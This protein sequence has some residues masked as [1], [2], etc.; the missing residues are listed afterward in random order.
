MIGGNWKWLIVSDMNK[1]LV[2]IRGVLESYL[3]LLKNLRRQ[4]LK[5]LSASCVKLFECFY[6]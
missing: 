1:P 2:N 6:M 3:Q 5:F 4:K